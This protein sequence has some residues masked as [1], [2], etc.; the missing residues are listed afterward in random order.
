[1]KKKYLLLII[2]II[3]LIIFDLTTKY[4]ANLYLQEK[5]VINDFFCFLLSKNKYIAFSIPIPLI[6]QI[7]ITPFLL[8]IFIAYLKENL[9]SKIIFSGGLLI[10]SGAVGNFIERIFYGE[11]TDFIDFSFWPSFNL[12]DSFITLGAILIIMGE[13]Y[14]IKKL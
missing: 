11:V 13:M 5:I 9:K 14:Q 2:L 1:M 8:A 7:L 6:V 3:I 12:A 4:F 10:I